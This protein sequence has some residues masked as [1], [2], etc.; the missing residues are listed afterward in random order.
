MLPT[1]A[2]STPRIDERDEVEDEDLPPPE[3]IGQP[4]ED[5]CS[6]EDARQ[7]RGA[8]QPFLNGGEV[9][10]RRG[11]R[12]HDADDAEVVAVEPL[13]ERGRGRDPAQEPLVGRARTRRRFHGPLLAHQR[14]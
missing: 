1:K 12:K 13:P 5:G 3:A 10:R 6:E 7:R 4:A 11:Q 9:E 2:W 8:E 14:S